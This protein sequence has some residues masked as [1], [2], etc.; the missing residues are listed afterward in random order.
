MQTVLLVE[1]DY[2]SQEVICVMLK[3]V[4]IEVDVVSSGAEALEQLSKAT[5][6]LAIIDLGLPGI[7]GWEVLK[8]I[9]H[10][11]ETN[12]LPCVA[13]TAY[14]DSVVAQEAIEAGFDAY[15]P[16]PLALSFGKD[17]SRVL[18]GG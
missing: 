16:K 8:R 18:A 14:H 9:R 17:I 6:P 4:D 15:F 3:H 11:P 2:Y 10:N 13:I 1:D 12:G 7:S 5:Y